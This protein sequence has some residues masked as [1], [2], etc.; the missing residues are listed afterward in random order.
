MLH[1]ELY[2]I[3]NLAKQVEACIYENG[4]FIHINIQ[5]VKISEIKWHIKRI[6]NRVV[7]E[8][9]RKSWDRKEIES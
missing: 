9:E 7:K 5:A 8:S 4:I 2:R 3:Q 6:F 1:T